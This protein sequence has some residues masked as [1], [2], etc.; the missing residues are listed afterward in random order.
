MVL[1]CTNDIDFY[2]ASAEKIGRMDAVCQISDVDINNLPNNTILIIDAETF[3]KDSVEKH[4]D[5]LVFFYGCPLIVTRAV[6]YTQ[7]FEYSKISTDVAV[8]SGMD[9]VI[10]AITE[11]RKAHP[12]LLE[13]GEWTLH[14][15]NKELRYRG[16]LVSVLND[17]SF[18]LL[19][20]LARNKNQMVGRETL[21]R[22]CWTDMTFKKSRSMDV[23]IVKLKH[24]FERDERIMIYNEYGIGF[25]LSVKE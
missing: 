3:Q 9:E 8:A 23:Y 11:I 1:V 5:T 12:I 10:E 24:L 19:C 13:F 16:E 6:R 7:Y 20:E 15:V 18:Y 14:I 17:K 2:N 21:M 22:L 25:C 4:F